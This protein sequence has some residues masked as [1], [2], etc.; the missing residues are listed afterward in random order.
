MTVDHSAWDALLRKYVRPAPDGANG[1]AY[2]AVTTAEKQVLKDY[3]TRLQAPKVSAIDDDEQRAFWINLYNA[4]TVDLVLDHYPL[5]SVRDIVEGGPWSKPRAIV[6]GRALSLSNI[7]HDVLRKLWHDPRVHYAVNCASGSCPNLMP[8]A[9]TGAALEAMLTQGARDYVNHE[10][11]VR[12]SAGSAR[13]S[14]IFSWYARDFGSDQAALIAHLQQYASPEL[15]ERL[16][17]VERI[18]S[19]DYDWSL[20]DATSHGD[21]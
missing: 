13:L 16:S 11:A 9:F 15:R 4:L 14:R 8:R 5:K 6:E 18:T 3:I 12:A 1:F 17:K 21:G 7:E 10:R 2:G 20:N 19:Y